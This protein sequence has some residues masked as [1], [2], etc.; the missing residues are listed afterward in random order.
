MDH[1]RIVGAG[2]AAIAVAAGAYWWTAADRTEEAAPAA[3]PAAAPGKLSPQQIQRL[4]IT[5]QAAQ[6]KGVHAG[7][8][9]KEVAK[10]AGGGGGGRA[11][12]AQAGGKNPESLAVALAVAKTVVENQV[13][14]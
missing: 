12:M 8:I 11:D 10:A 13:R 3:Q 5:T 14:K 2:L 4:G 9:I 7:N 6:A 1:K